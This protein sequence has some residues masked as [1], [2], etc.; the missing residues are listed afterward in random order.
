MRGGSGLLHITMFHW[1]LCFKSYLWA[2]CPSLYLTSLYWLI[3]FIFPPFLLSPLHTRNRQR[4]KAP[5]FLMLNEMSLLLCLFEKSCPPGIMSWS[6]VFRFSPFSRSENQTCPYEGFLLGIW[7]RGLFSLKSMYE[8]I[9][10]QA[11][12]TSIM[13]YITLHKA[14]EF[15]V[16]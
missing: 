10:V 15:I 3:M 13:H 1:R 14:W 16:N 9:C 8:K 2:L 11:Q 6:C 4:C 5:L 7:V 12:T